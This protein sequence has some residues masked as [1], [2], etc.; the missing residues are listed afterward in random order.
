MISSSCWS[1]VWRGIFISAFDFIYNVFIE[2][3][4]FDM[5]CDIF[6]VYCFINLFSFFNKMKCV[7]EGSFIIVG[8][9]D[10]LFDF[11][12]LFIFLVV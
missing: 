12:I 9:F 6:N 3:D 7:Y 1:L 4:M 8:K 11:A 2:F 5:V 10:L